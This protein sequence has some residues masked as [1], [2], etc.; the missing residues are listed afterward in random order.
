MGFSFFQLVTHLAVRHKATAPASTAGRTPRIT[1]ASW[2][3][4]VA[5]ARPTAVRFPGSA[6]NKDPSAAFC[7]FPDFPLLPV[8]A[9]FVPVAFSEDVCFLLSLL[10][11]RCAIAGRQ[12]RDILLLHRIPLSVLANASKSHRK[13]I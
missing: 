13:S 12:G 3:S 6:G 5:A 7:G 2:A 10:H 11:S 4:P 1:P 9:F 8:L